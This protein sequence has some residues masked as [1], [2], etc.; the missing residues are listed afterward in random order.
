MEW[1]LKCRVTASDSARTNSSHAFTIIFGITL[2]KVTDSS[3]SLGFCIGSPMKFDMPL[4]RTSKTSLSLSLSL[5]LT[6]THI[7]IYIYILSS[8]DSF[9]VSQLFN[10]ARHARCF[11]QGSNLNISLISYRVIVILSVREENLYAYIYIYICI[12]AYIYRSTQ[13][14]R[15]AL[16]LH[17]H[18]HIYIYIVIHRQI[19]FVLSELISVVWHISFA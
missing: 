3:S 7:Y 11:K 4:N 9:V 10:V 12:Y 8:T 19:C 17:T 13:F 15:I 18:T 1:W 5:S 16:H 14:M 6:H 2:G